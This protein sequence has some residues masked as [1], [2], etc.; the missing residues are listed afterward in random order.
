MLYTSYFAHIKNHPRIASGELRAMSIALSTPFG[1]PDDEWVPALRPWPF[2]EDQYKSDRLTVTGYE[3]R[4]RE[5]VLR[6]VSAQFILNHYDNCVLCCH[7]SPGNWCHRSIVQKWIAEKTG[8]IVQELDDL[9]DASCIEC[10]GGKKSCIY[11]PWI[12]TLKSGWCNALNIRQPYPRR[13]GKAC[14]FYTA[15]DPV[16][17]KE[18]KI[19]EPIQMSLF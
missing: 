6:N 14:S 10:F 5:C 15:K 12:G 3:F 19:V 18:K 4:Y 13:D 7:E 1:W 11:G 2:M 8:V 16:I 9:A 17:V